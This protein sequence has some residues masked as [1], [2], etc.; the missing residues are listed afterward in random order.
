MHREFKEKF[1]CVVNVPPVVVTEMFHTLTLDCTAVSNPGDCG[2]LL[3]LI[4]TTCL[5]LQ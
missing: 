5:I 4:M 1:S 2:S 3:M